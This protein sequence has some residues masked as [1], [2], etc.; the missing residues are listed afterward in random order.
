M[1]IELTVILGGISCCEDS[2]SVTKSINSITGVQ[3]VDISL[4]SEEAKIVYD[5][6]LTDSQSIIKTIEDNGLNATIMTESKDIPELLNDKDIYETSVGITGMTCGAC[7]ASITN[8][9]EKLPGVQSVSVNLITEDGLIKHYGSLTTNQIIEEIEDCGFDAKLISSDNLSLKLYETHLKIDGMT[10]GSC[11]ATI[12]RVLE[13]TEGVSEVNVSLLTEEAVVVHK[14]NQLSVK[15]LITTVED[16]GF[17]ARLITSAQFNATEDNEER[18]VLQIY[19]LQEIEDPNDFKYNL[20]AI[21]TSLG[22][23]ITSYQLNENSDVHDIIDSHGH[24]DSESS[25]ALLRT[26]SRDS[27]IFQ[28]D[29]HLVNEL[30]IN[31]NSELIGARDLIEKLNSLEESVNF[32]IL[33]S[34][35]QTSNLQLKLLSKIK[36]ISYWRSNF[37]KSCILG[38]PI[39]V[40]SH[41]QNL[42]FWKTKLIFDGLFWSTFI[43]ALLA[44]YIQFKLGITFLKKLYLYILVKGSSATMDVLVAIST[45]ISFTFSVVSMLISVWNGTTDKAPVVLF[46]TSAMLITFI[47]FGK[48]L[49]NKAKGATSTALSKLVSLTPTSCMIV[50]DLEKYQEYINL[51]KAE[52]AGDDK[53]SENFPTRNIEI[54]LVQRNDITVV[55]PGSKVPADGRVVFGGSEVDESLL[56]GESL[57]IYKKAG[58]TV[59]G[60]S[61]NGSGLLHVLVTKTGKN[62][63]LQ[64]VI[65]LVKDSQINK[66][67][68]QRYSDYVA[69]KFVPVVLLLA[70]STFLFWFTICF[71]F[72]KNL[73]V[74]FN[75][76]ENG[77]YF[78]CLKIAIS[79]IVVACPCALGLASPTAIMVGT[80]LG[81]QNG[82]LIKGG[83]VLEKANN[84]NIILFD[85]TGTLTTGKM[86]LSDFKLFNS[87]I[88]LYDWWSLIGS[89]ESNSGHPIANALIKISKKEIGLFEEDTFSPVTTDFESIIGMGAK[90]SLK[91]NNQD[92]EVIIG[93]KKLMALSG[94]TF[95]ELK[96]ANTVIYV[97]INGIY[98]GY[99][100]LTDEL[101]PSTKTV[102]NNLKYKGNYIVGMVTGDNSAVA[103]KIGEQ[104][105]ILKSNIFSEVSPTNKDQI[106]VQLREKFG[107]SDNVGI[108]F[109]GDGINDAPALSQA[110]IGI[111]ISN[112]TDIAIES[113]NIV[114]MNDKSNDISGIISALDISRRTFQRIKY[115]FI[116]ATGYNIMMV[117][118]AM[119]LFLPFGLMLPPMAAG[120]SMAVSSISVVLSSLMLNTWKLNMDTDYRNY[121]QEGF[122][123][124]D[125]L[126]SSLREFADFKKKSSKL[127]RN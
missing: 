63:Q 101:R 69:S 98:Q 102:I 43:Q 120:F 104:V 33:N 34:I 117:P 46:E 20:E 6:N 25:T 23:S 68:I 12:T 116:W 105:G 124:F 38:L 76:E 97:G 70:L 78:V 113:A 5:S 48:W 109:V 107:G 26:H 72:P 14:L 61:V 114:I 40:L 3:S 88:P 112:G 96:S 42:E 36:E 82:V 99:I 51:L 91:F 11:S 39:I 30:T 90:G 103:E 22:P 87:E 53:A 57:P 93:N 52:K 89:L 2:N 119:G 73:P 95:D 1:L 13:K 21:L 118:F 92:Y 111:A 56:T 19:G 65:K 80:G 24:H 108:A 106:V 83:D 50:S 126:N 123:D 60:G 127:F 10:C 45:L 81:A 71:F 15:E 31:Y 77:K 122:Q 59:I 66:A 85:K 27:E 79:V 55:L 125:L 47:S 35:D 75:K 18:L 7:S 8:A 86:I 44:T 100:E 64:K 9:L 16:C 121:D 84:L 37:V 58:D 94:I 54:D 115:N 4:V 49:E 67:P 32:L 74:M 29:D 41:T 62:S 17:D 28:N 110:D